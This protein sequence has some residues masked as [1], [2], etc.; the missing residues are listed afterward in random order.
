MKEVSTGCTWCPPWS[1]NL[2]GGNIEGLQ[3]EAV[4]RVHRAILELAAAEE[5]LAKIQY[6]WATSVLLQEGVNRGDK[7][8]VEYK[9]GHEVAIFGGIESRLPNNIDVH[10]LT[11]KG[12][13]EK[14]PHQT[15]FTMA[16]HIRRWDP[17][18]DA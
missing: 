10:H 7:V 5:V 18:S 1:W 14:R 13:P 8:V 3:E 17:K 6:H 12:T 4:N 16:K 15:A 9:D 2:I 11:K